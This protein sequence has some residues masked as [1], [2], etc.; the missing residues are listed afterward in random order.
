M[1]SQ[2]SRKLSY[3]KDTR[4][5]AEE[6]DQ[7]VIVVYLRIDEGKESGLVGHVPI[8]I[9]K[10][11]NQFLEANNN[12]GLKA[13]VTGKNKRELGLIVP[14]KYTAMNTGSCRTKKYINILK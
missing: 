13:T 4:A 7:N 11:T 10:L 5:E 9:S 12:N 6:Y 1:D 2:F 8:E 3:V 14:A